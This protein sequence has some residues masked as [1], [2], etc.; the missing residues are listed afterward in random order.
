MSVPKNLPAAQLELDPGRRGDVGPPQ[1][2][3]D[4]TGVIENL[5]D[6]QMMMAV[7]TQEVLEE[8]YK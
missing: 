3:G 6:P 7:A 4:G 8:N 1:P 5:L 2:R